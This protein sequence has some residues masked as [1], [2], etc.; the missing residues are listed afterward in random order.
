MATVPIYMF[1]ISSVLYNDKLPVLCCRRT[2][3]SRAEKKGKLN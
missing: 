3:E 1:V 2:E